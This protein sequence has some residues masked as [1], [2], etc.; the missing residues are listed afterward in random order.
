MMMMGGGIIN[1]ILWIL[2]LGFVIYGVMMLVMK[3]FEKKEDSSL[4][5]LRERY[6][7]GEIDE[8]EFEQRKSV[9]QKNK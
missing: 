2:L 9:L 4:Q 3:P 7:R 1:M 8:Q 6:A 5:V